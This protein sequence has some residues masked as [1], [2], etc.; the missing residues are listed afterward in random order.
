[1]SL[2][3]SPRIDLSDLFQTTFR[4]THRSRAITV[5]RAKVALPVDQ[6]QAQGEILRHAHKGF[7]DRAI[8]MRVILTHYVTDHGGPIYG[9]ACSTRSHSHTWNKE[10]VDAPA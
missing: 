5:N 8:T 9:K 10:C 1:M 7:I 2:S 4:V 3:R 6:R